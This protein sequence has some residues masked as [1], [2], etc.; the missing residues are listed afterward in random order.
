LLNAQTLA[1][2]RT[3]R[4]SFDNSTFSLREKVDADLFFLA[5]KNGRPFSAEKVR[6]GEGAK[7]CFATDFARRAKPRQ[8]ASE[9]R[10]ADEEI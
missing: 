3:C 2:L 6:R 7:R 9:K 4:T 5:R 1:S 8:A 10:D